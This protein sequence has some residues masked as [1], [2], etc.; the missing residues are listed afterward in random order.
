MCEQTYP[1]FHAK[2]KL[3]EASASGADECVRPYTSLLDQC[4]AVAVRLFFWGDYNG[5]RY[6]VAWLQ[7]QQADA[8]GVAARFPDR[9]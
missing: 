9:G 6:F 7:I 1:G 3:R 8:L 2:C 4:S 5:C